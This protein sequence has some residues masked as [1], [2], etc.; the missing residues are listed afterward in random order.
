L[1]YFFGRLVEEVFKVNASER[2]L[3]EL[4]LLLEFGGMQSL[5][6]VSHFCDK[7]SHNDAVGGNETGELVPET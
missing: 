1:V 2:E 5:G 3:A 7:S 6:V 4:A